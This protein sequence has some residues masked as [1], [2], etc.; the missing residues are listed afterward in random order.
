VGLEKTREELEA[1]TALEF[2]QP[3][4]RPA[5][6]KARGE[7]LQQVAKAGRRLVIQTRKVRERVRS[8]RQRA[9]EPPSRHLRRQCVPAA[10]SF[11][12]EPVHKRGQLIGVQ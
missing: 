9:H 2:M 11:Q 3:E 1:H 7:A 6:C 8:A 10:R 5:I 4:R 12:A